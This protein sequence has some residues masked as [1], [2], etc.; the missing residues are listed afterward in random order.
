MKTHHT[1]EQ[2]QVAIDAACIDTFAAGIEEKP[3][4]FLHL[5]KSALDRLPEPPPPPVVDGKTP[6]QVN[7]EA[8]AK[9]DGNNGWNA[10][11]SAVLAAFGKKPAKPWTPAVGDVVKLK[12][13]GPKM[14]VMDVEEN[15]DLWCQWFQEDGTWL[16]TDFPAATLQPA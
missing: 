16:G 10:G 4:R 5:L 14:T 13:G 8:F 9:A 6:G 15:G 11:A 1:D 2:M 3:E 12:S 7:L